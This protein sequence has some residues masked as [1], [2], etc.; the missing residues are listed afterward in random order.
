MAILVVDDFLEGLGVMK[1]YLTFTLNC[2]VFTADSVASAE[3]LLKL[4]S[5]DLV[6]SDFD[7]PGGNGLKLLPSLPKNVPFILYTGGE[8]FR[9]EIQTQ[10]RN[11]FVVVKPN[12]E[13]LVS[14]ISKLMNTANEHMDFGKT[15]PK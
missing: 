7:M 12:I 3:Q 11:I 5:I 2:E 13:K 14:T 8:N 9:E 10:D 1:E 4:H 15:Q 6:V